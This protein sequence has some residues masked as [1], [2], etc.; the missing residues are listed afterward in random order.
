MKKIR[1][2]LFSK[3][4][5]MFAAIATVSCA[6]LCLTAGGWMSATSVWAQTAPA[7][8]PASD[9]T[10]A[11][12]HGHAQDPLA[13][14][15]P[16]V[17]VELTHDGKTPIYTFTTSEYGDY[18]GSGIAPGKYAV[19]LYG[20]VQG[21]DGKMA[22]GTM[23]FQKDVVFAAGQDVQVDFDMTRAEYVDKLPADVRAHIKELRKKNS[24]AEEANKAIKNVNKLILDARAARKAGNFDQAIALDTQ[25]TVG[26]PDSGLTWFE[27]GDS[28]LA[29]K[30]YPDAITNYQ[31][32]LPLMTADKSAKPAVIS[33]AYNNLG[34]AQASSGKVPD[35]VT[36]YEAAAKADP[37][38]A[39]MYYTNEAIVLYKTGQGDA[40]SAAAD[41][42]IAADPSKAIPYYI[43]GWALVQHATVDPKTNKIVLP[44]GCADAYRKFLKLSPTGPL[45]ADAENILKQAGEST[46]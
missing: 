13:Q 29:A 18:T 26:K 21:P 27:L 1:F 30:K 22:P 2:A 6:A 19:L 41:K 9:A 45:A 31:K 28:Y 46:H 11:K 39:G 20:N 24:G 35:A 44:A 4:A 32:A 8:A 12:I 38:Q 33:A 43:K 7:A 34:E 42:A 37:T 16:N 25:A 15:E 3:S 14:P 23:D 17:K 5:K 10:T 36:S 40:A